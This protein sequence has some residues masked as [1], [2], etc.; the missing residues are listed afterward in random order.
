MLLRKRDIYK[1]NG[2]KCMVDPQ[3]HQMHKRMRYLLHLLHQQ[4]RI[5]IFF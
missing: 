5:V 4:M 2:R 1:S 3:H